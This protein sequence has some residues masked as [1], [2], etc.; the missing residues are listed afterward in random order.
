MSARAYASGGL[1]CWA[2]SWARRLPRLDEER[3]RR[4]SHI[5]LHARRPC[6]HPPPWP[7]HRLHVKALGAAV[8]AEGTREA[9]TGAVRRG[10][11]LASSS[12]FADCA[13]GIAATSPAD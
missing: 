4:F 1:R 2:G 6:T 12:R 7:R 10:P 8:E 5:T 11:L 9:A 3:P 13:T